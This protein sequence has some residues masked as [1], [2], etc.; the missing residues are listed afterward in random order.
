MYPI[1]QK[2]YLYLIIRIIKIIVKYII[3][4]IDY[5]FQNKNIPTSN[6]Q[7]YLFDF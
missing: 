5:N 4:S 2:L 3:V 7:N 1:K 6:I